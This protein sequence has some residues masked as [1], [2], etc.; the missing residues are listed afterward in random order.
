MNYMIIS[1]IRKIG[2]KLNWL[3]WLILAYFK[4]KPVKE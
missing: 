3:S 1:F 2:K 4:N